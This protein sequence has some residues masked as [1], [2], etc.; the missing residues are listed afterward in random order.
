MLGSGFPKR[1][2]VVEDLEYIDGSIIF[3]LLR[4]EA[5]IPLKSSTSNVCWD[6]TI[7]ARDDN[8]EEDTTNKVNTFRTGIGLVPPKGYHFE[9]V[10][11]TILADQGYI[12]PSTIIINPDDNEEIVVPLIKFGNTEDLELPCSYLQLVLRETNY[13]NF[14]Q[15]VSKEAVQKQTAHRTNSNLKQSK[16]KSTIVQK[17]KKGNSFY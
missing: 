6:L 14:V 13:C 16:I 2:I 7:V 3:S 4:P 17:K 1:K 11:K 10:A 15:K 5:S 9:I 8:R 12:L